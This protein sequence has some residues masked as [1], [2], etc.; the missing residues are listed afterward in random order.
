MGE[1]KIKNCF[2]HHDKGYFLAIEIQLGELLA[3]DK[4]LIDPLKKITILEV[5]CTNNKYPNDLILT[6]PFEISDI[7]GEVKISDLYGMRFQTISEDSKTVS[8]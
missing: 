7:L 5:L 1:I 2:R 6:V 8:E 3:G 4:I